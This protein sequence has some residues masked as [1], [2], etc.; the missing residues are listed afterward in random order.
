M[1]NKERVIEEFKRL[2]SFDSESFKE[3]EISEYVYNTLKDLGLDLTIDNAG[4]LL[5]RENGFDFKHSKGNIYGYLKGTGNDSV[6]FSSHLDT[7]SPGINKKA[8]I[9]E[10]GV[11]KSDGTTV[12]GADDISGLVSIIEALRIIKENNLKH[13]DI[14][15]LISIAEEPYCQGTKYFDFSK[16]KSKKAY[17]LDLDGPVGNAA[18]S[19]PSIISFTI[20]IFGLSAHAGFHPE[21]GINAIT[22]LGNALSK[23]K[24]GRLNE[25]TL[26]NFGKVYGGLQRNS[27]PDYVNIIGEVRSL[28][29]EEAIQT[30]DGV[31]AIFEEE[32]LKIGGKIKLD[33]DVKIEAYN[34]KKDSDTVK[35]FIN[36][37]SKLGYKGPELINTFGGSDNNNLNKHG[38]QGIVISSGMNLCHTV[39]EY[40]SVDELIKSI[41]IVLTL[42]LDTK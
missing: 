18:I 34:V 12:L 29:R 11:I 32:A 41:K 15:V 16:I 40:T 38:I 1:I 13:K 3:I 42:M 22:I 27:V 28:D 2:V 30:L 35:D 24:V 19:A 26:L 17:V 9:D 25:K 5:A 14:E 33:Y 36:A 31:K 6:L 7:V 20:E 23:I 21:D 39:N 8:I 37:L 10:N 4:D